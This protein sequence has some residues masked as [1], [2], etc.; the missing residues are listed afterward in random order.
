MKCT[1]VF[2][3]N[4]KAVVQRKRL[5]IN[6]GGARSSKTYSILQLIV[7][8]AQKAKGNRIISVVSET[9]PHLKKGAMR[10]FIQILEE[11]NL[12]SDAMHNKTD[13]VFLI[14]SLCGKFTSKVEFFSADSSSKVRGP[15]R[16]Y[17]F[18]NEC[19]NIDYETYYQLLTRTAYSVFLDYNPT[20]EFWV[21]TEI[22]AH[23]HF[24]E[25]EFIKS[26]YRD[27][28]FLS[29]NQR[30]DIISRSLRDDNYRLVYAEGEIG[31]LEGL[32][33]KSWSIV[34]DMPITDKR[35]IGVDFG[36]TNDPTTIVDVRQ[37]NGEW[38]VDEC[39]YSTGLH[40]NQIANIIK[41]MNVGACR[42][43]CDSAEAK[44]IDD[45]KRMGISAEPCI[46]GADSIVNGLEYVNSQPLFVTRRSVN[47]HKELRNYK[48]K[49][50]KDG[51]P[52]NEPVDNWNH[53][54]DAM[55][56][57]CVGFKKTIPIRT[58]KYSF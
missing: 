18:I 57:A 2:N 11:D 30:K 5:I 26:T 47:A 32:I 46:K 50:S 24:S 35:I 36:F 25:W 6:Q 22:L 37:Y 14:K 44:T 12:Y 55:R 51:K 8:I 28:N 42:I 54:I 4:L 34:D 53:F 58:A 49:V 27:N 38:Y 21:H 19:N 39:E 52:M 10:D 7:L 20:S 1:E 41:G 45:L 33:F 23:S 56:Y 29:E 15:Q 17:L 16:D 31:S 40:N 13:N 48:W 9:F 43:I 3:R